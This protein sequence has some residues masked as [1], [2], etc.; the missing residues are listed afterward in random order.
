MFLFHLELQKSIGSSTSIVLAIN[1]T[2]TA[3]SL[4]MEWVDRYSNSFSKHVFTCAATGQGIQNLEM[5]ISEIVGLNNMP[6]EGGNR[7]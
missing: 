2:D 5:T 6:V 1:K 7:Q 3:A 4:C